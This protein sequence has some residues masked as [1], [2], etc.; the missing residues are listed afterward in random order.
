LAV[1]RKMAK[2]EPA[3]DRMRLAH[4]PVEELMPEHEGSMVA[5]AHADPIRWAPDGLPATAGLRP[6]FYVTL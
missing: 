1:N 3:F 5:H 6:K 2:A 4:A